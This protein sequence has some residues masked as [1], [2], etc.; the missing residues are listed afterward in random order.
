MRHRGK[1]GWALR[2]ILGLLFLRALVP[3]GFMLAPVDGWFAVV[4]CDGEMSAGA[5]PHHH[6]HP[7]HNAASSHEGF[8]IDPTC[9]YAQSAGSVPLPSL[10][11]MAGAALV[12]RLP[13]ADAATQ[14]ILT[15]G[16]V[17]R[18]LPRGPPLL[19]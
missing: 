13:T 17:R 8:H 4:V 2:L 16:P 12:A 9:P 15:A 19:A 1:S 10:P 5:H 7:D 18:Q 3:A 14:S 6:H 11:V